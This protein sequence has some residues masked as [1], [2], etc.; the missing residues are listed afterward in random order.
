[1]PLALEILT[2]NIFASGDFYDG[3]LLNAALTVP[4]SFW[5]ENPLMYASM[6]ELLER[7]KDSLDSNMEIKSVRRTISDFLNTNK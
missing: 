3:D 5:K 2:K 1:M 6:K 7:Q 4:D